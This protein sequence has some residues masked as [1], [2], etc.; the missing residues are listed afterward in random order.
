[1]SA[2]PAASSTGPGGS[3]TTARA[4][5]PPPGARARGSR[6]GAAAP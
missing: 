1:M 3:S 2:R 4:G 6:R 5:R